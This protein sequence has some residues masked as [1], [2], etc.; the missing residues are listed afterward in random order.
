MRH[1]SGSSLF[2]KVTIYLFGVSS[3]QMVKTAVQLYLTIT[4]STHRAS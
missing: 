1:P 4:I 3:K 2:V